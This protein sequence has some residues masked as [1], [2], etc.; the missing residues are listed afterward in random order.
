MS[1]GATPP[2]SPGLSPTAL[3][4]PLP[5][6]N[7]PNPHQVNNYR[8]ELIVIEPDTALNP[9]AAGALEPPTFMTLDLRTGA[10]SPVRFV[11]SARNLTHDD[12]FLFALVE[13]Y[14]YPADRSRIIADLDMGVFMLPTEVEGTYAF[15]WFTRDVDAEE[16][17]GVRV[18]FTMRFDEEDYP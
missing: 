7:I 8:S 14:W 13:G 6:V 17:G 10:A 2:S 11:H 3:L 18:A 12:K 16:A 4:G 5:S 15:H 9:S 1:P